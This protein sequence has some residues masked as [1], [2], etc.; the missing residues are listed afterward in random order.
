MAKL[1]TPV[2]PAE[3]AATEEVLA[4]KRGERD[5]EGWLAPGLT[6]RPLTSFDDPGRVLPSLGAH[7][8]RT[9]PFEQ[10]GGG[11][12]GLFSGGSAGDPIADLIVDHVGGLD[13]GVAPVDERQRQGQL[14]S[15]AGG[16]EHRFAPPARPR[17]S[18]TRNSSSPSPTATTATSG[19]SSP[20]AS[21]V[22][23]G[24]MR[25]RLTSAPSAS[26]AAMR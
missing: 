7:Q 21:P 4:I 1:V 16:D 14:V 23:A 11:E 8:L 6:T 19:T 12:A 26:A 20:S 15:R 17:A 18:R 13:H 5:E 9:R 3:L 25:S 2:N 24:A 22:K 10:W